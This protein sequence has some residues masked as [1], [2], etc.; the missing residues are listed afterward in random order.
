M[1]TRRFVEEVGL[2]SEDYFLYFEELDWVLRGTKRFTLGYADDSILYHKEGGTIG[3]KS[4]KRAS[5]LSLFYLTRNRLLF[6]RKFFPDSTVPVVFRLF[7]ECAVYA[8]RRDF[9]ALSIVAKCLIFDLLYR[10]QRTMGFG[11][12]EIARFLRPHF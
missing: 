2:M 11:E 5:N 9:S 6:T 3:S 12:L 7:F 4:E 8:K 10:P 1:V